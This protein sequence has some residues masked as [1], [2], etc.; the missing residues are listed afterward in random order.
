M[1]L[2]VS[3]S[4]FLA[5]LTS[6]VDRHALTILEQKFAIEFVSTQVAVTMLP[7]AEEICRDIKEYC[8]SAFCVFYSE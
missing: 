7:M 6:M 2:F 4:V 8:S 3:A 1:L 5:V